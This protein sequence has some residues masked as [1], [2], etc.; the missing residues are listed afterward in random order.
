MEFTCQD[1][2]NNEDTAPKDPLELIFSNL[3][4]ICKLGSHGYQEERTSANNTDTEAS[5]CSSGDK[6]QHSLSF[7]RKLEQTGSRIAVT[8]ADRVLSEEF[9]QTAL[10]R[11]N[12]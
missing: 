1:F 12:L 5:T 3:D 4:L 10:E 8:R 6:K 9:E 2:L 11:F 7:W